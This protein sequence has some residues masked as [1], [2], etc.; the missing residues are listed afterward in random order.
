MQNARTGELK[1]PAGKAEEHVC[2]SLTL[3]WTHFQEFGEACSA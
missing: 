1:E 3:K 2:A